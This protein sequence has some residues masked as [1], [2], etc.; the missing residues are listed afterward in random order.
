MAGVTV[1]SR[2]LNRLPTMDINIGR[3]P[4]LPSMQHNNDTMDSNITLASR[5]FRNLTAQ[6]SSSEQPETASTHNM[7][8]TASNSLPPGAEYDP[9]VVDR[10]MSFHPAFAYSISVGT[11]TMDFDRNMVL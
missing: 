2:D 4:G 8:G 10:S 6:A 9:E 3:A 11:V 1:A 7:A 5:M